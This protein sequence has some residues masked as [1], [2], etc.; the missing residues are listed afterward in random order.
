MH[1]LLKLLRRWLKQ[2]AAIVLIISGIITFPLPLPIG[3]ILI[4]IGLALLITTNR[5]VAKWIKERRIKTPEL[6]SRFSWLEKKLPRFFSRAIRKTA[7]DY[8]Q[9]KGSEVSKKP[10]EETID[11]SESQKPQL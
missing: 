2:I 10:Y 8:G 11:T 6:N 9:K 3:A 1:S 5:T 7:P 4:A